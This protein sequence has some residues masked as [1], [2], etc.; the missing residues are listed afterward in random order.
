MKRLLVLLVIVAGI[1]IVLVAA[2]FM[3]AGDSTKIAVATATVKRGTFETKLPENGIV[4]R[5]RTATIPTLVAGNLGQIYAQAGDA[6]SAGQLL[7]TVDNPTL[8][9]N[10]ASS[11][12]DYDQ[13]QASIQTARTNSQNA[14]VTYQADVQTA[15]SNLDEARR[16]YNADVALYA[17]KAIPRNQ[18]DVDKAKLDQTEVQYDQAVRQARLGAVTGYSQD[19]VQMAVANAHKMAI[20]NSANQQQLGFTRIVAPFS[21]VIQ[22]VATQ[23]N[24]PL[25]NL[26]P[27]DPVTAGQALFTIAESGN[28]IVK[29]QVDE[30]DVINVHVGQPAV[31][32]GED[33]PGKHLHGHVADISPIATK[34]TDASST[35]KQ[36]LTT[37]LLDSSPSY[38][39]DGM[40]VDI[41]IL[42]SDVKNALLVP[43]D[44]IVSESGKAYVFVVRNHVAHKTLVQSGKANDTQTI[45]TSGLA[46]GDVIV[47]QKTPGLLD[48]EAVTIAP[49]PSPNPASP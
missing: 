15:K 30:Q 12:A 26:R 18:L 38:L 41:D 37:I 40:T 21:G 23:P 44:A 35:A 25:T 46:A 49:S 31:V 45:V 20:V 13:A 11:Q 34:S 27:G 8:E 2:K 6:V 33:F 1:A 10:A 36:V 5:P 39:R 29:A 47:A 14:Q 3:R 43:N 4:Q 7:A 42:T 17:S 9:S 24:D 48:K 22:S 16:I 28:Y 32:S 19:S